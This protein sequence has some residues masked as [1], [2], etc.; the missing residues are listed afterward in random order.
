MARELLMQRH[1]GKLVPA[2]Q[3]A[4]EDLMSRVEYDTN[5]GCWLWSGAATQSSRD[6]GRGSVQVGPRQSEWAYRASYRTFRGNIPAGMLVCHRCDVPACINPDH[7]FLGTHADNTADMMAK[8]RGSFSSFEG[9]SKAGKLGGRSMK[10]RA[11]GERVSNAR[12]TE[13]EV[14]ELRSLNGFV[15]MAEAGRLYGISPVNV[16]YIWQRKTWRHVA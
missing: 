3:M 4:E 11:R 7:L 9:A 10:N 13:A 6:Y 14:R 15:T 8:R 2:D 16:R 1:G 12:L 5:G